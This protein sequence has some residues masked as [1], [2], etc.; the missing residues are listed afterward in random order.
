MDSNRFYVYAYLDP[1]KRQDIDNHGLSFIPLYIGKGTRHRLTEHMKELSWYM[2]AKP[3]FQELRNLRS[4]LLKLNKLQS[5]IEDGFTPIIIKLYKNLSED[6]AYKLEKE[7]IS[8]YGRSIDGGVLTNLTLG[9]DGRRNVIAAG[10]F[11]SFYGRTHSEEFKQ[12]M[13]ALHKGKT[14]SVEHRNAI[15]LAS[16]GHRKLHHT[17]EAIRSALVRLHQDDPLNPGCEMKRLA[18]SKQWIV[19]SPSGEVF[20]V[21]SLRRFCEQH[22][23]PIKTMMSAKNRNGPV[24][25]GPAS[26]W[27]VVLMK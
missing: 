24:L 20:N 14:I 9:G 2:E 6:A 17:K 12:K 4:N 11:N 16:K 23:L 3:S 10:P 27:S 13:S 5:I 15:S 25:S 7:L 1:R 21:I 22:S 26:G 18:R 8:F 19:T